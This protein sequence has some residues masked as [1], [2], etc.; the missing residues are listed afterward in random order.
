MENKLQ[1][2]YSEEFGSLD[3]LMVGDKPYFPATEC[4]QILG[5]S[6]PRHAISRHCKGGTKRAVLTGGGLQ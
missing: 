4:A 1:Q 3:I 5:Y 2:F 6:T